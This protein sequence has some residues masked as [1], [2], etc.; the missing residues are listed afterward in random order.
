M[1]L[2]FYRKF[3]LICFFIVFLSACNFGSGNSS[4][5]E[6]FKENT[7]PVEDDPEDIS[8]PEEPAETDSAVPDQGDSTPPPEASSEAVPM[9]EDQKRSPLPSMDSSE[10]EPVAPDQGDSTPPSEAVLAEEGQKGEASLPPEDSSKPEKVLDFLLPNKRQELSS[11]DL[12]SSG[13]LGTGGFDLFY[14]YIRF[15]F[16]R[17]GPVIQR[18]PPVYKQKWD[19]LCHASDC[20]NGLDLRKVKPQ[21]R[22]VIE[23]LSFIPW[24]SA[25]IKKEDEVTVFLQGHLA[26]PDWGP[27][28]YESLKE[29]ETPLHIQGVHQMRNEMKERSVKRVVVNLPLQQHMDL[30]PFFILGQFI[31]ENQLDLHIV[32]GCGPYCARYLIP[33][34]KT[35]YIEPYGYIYF[36]GGF[37]GISG[38]YQAILSPAPVQTEADKKHWREQ[39][40]LELKDKVGFINAG[41]GEIMKLFDSGVSFMNTFS[42]VW[43]PERV[44]EFREQ[45]LSFEVKKTDL[46]AFTDEERKRLL[47]GLSPELLDSL[48]LFLKWAND[49]N[50]LRRVNYINDLQTLDQQESG[51]YK[52]I[53]INN[54]PSKKSYTYFGLF[55]L[56]AR[57]LKDVKYEKLFSV[58]KLY[59]YSVP[60]KDKPYS[61][62]FPSAD[63]LRSLGLDVRGKN[64]IGMLG[65]DKSSKK[66]VLYLD[67]RRIENCDFFAEGVSYTTE[68]LQGCLFNT[69]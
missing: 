4:K 56:A 11:E 20:L 69:N 14:Y 66:K 68:T 37:S 52:K 25:Y 42:E 49:E 55:Q 53:E 51:Y 13:V 6:I 43:D 62:V 7:E 46:K 9:E 29:G 39:W 59:Y 26:P 15:W 57:L 1:A 31:K 48:A 32:G 50:H 60:E 17:I 41:L 19:Q 33:A 65:V 67:N 12:L 58:P 24:V 44:L 8:P 61:I 28:S 16:N 23:W 45:L 35:V 47:E 3:L 38:M 21:M 18:A 64:N 40:L 30:Q 5:A 2:D 27:Q 22:N 63:L 54:L 10:T 36:N 34:A